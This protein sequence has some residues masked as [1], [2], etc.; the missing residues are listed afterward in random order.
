MDVYANHTFLPRTPVT[1]SELAQVASRLLARIAAEHPGERA[2]WEGKRLQFGDMPPEHLAYTDASAA[3]S[4]GVMTTKTG[5]SFQPL[6]T[7]SGAEA[8][9]AIAKLESLAAKSAAQSVPKIR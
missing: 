8:A 5:N 1:R 3:V 9:Q 7:V 6:S 2:A 4:A